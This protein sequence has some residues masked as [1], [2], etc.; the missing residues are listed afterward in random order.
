MPVPVSSVVA[1]DAQQ[2]VS[3]TQSRPMRYPPFG[4]GSV[5]LGTIDH[6]VPSQCSMSPW[7]PGA[8]PGKMGR[9]L[10]DCCPGP[11]L[12]TAQQSSAVRHCTFV[13]WS[14]VWPVGGPG[15]MVHAAPFHCSIRSLRLRPMLP[16]VEYPTAMQLD[17]DVQLTLCR[18]APATPA[19][20][21]VGLGTIDQAVPFQFSISVP[22]GLPP[23]AG[24]VQLGPHRPAVGTAH[25]GDVEEPPAVAG[26]QRAACAFSVHD[27][28]FQVST[29]GA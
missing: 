2:S 17:A 23:P 3:V 4:L 26:R 11:A 27:V 12:P 28:P 24:L 7:S 18:I 8:P 9:K 20:V 21:G 29:S 19:P 1:P 10:D 16:P 15:T 14:Y 13:S 25:A 6:V 22:I 5:T